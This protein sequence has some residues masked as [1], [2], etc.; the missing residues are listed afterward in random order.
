MIAVKNLLLFVTAATALLGSPGPGIAALLSVGRQ[1]GFAG[2]LRFYGGLQLGLAVAMALCAAGLFAAIKALPGG[3]I[4]LTLVGT[5]YLLWLGYQI[6]AAPVGAAVAPA[7]ALSTAKAGLLLG[8]SNPKAYLTF[9]ALL[10]FPPLVE[11]ADA[12][13]DLALK[14]GLCVVVM[15]VVD[16]AWLWAGAATRVLTL[17]PRHERGVNLAMGGTVALSALLGLL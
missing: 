4:A 6:A 13:A 9:G 12:V 8:A 3:V 16:L 10:A 17:S 7:R 11:P 15:V 2:G 1:K 5:L 14:A